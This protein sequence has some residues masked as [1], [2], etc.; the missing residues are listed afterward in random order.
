MSHRGGRIGFYGGKIGC[1]LKQGRGG[2]SRDKDKNKGDIGLF[3]R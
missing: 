1:I 3:M 2:L